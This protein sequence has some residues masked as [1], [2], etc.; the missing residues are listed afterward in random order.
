MPGGTTSGSGRATMLQ[1]SPDALVS[2]AQSLDVEG[3]ELVETLVQEAPALDAFMERAA[4]AA[5][6]LAEGAEP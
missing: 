3:V 6:A 5:E 2:I 1:G 4:E